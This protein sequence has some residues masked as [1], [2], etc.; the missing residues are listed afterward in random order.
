MGRLDGKVALVSGASRGIG[1]ACAVALAEDGADVLV[2]YL[3]HT[4]DAAETVG[5]IEALGRRAIAYRADVSDRAQ[6]DAM[7]AAALERLGRLDAVVANAYRSVRQPFLEVTPEGLA[8]TLSV[9]LFGAFHVCQA[10]ARAMVERGVEGSVTIVGSIHGE[11]AFAGATSY[12]LAKF[13]LTGMA[14]TA[15]NELARHRVRVNVINPGWIDTPGERNFASEEELRAAA[16]ALPWRRLG[17][18][19][20]IGR[21]AAFLASDDASFISGAVLRADGAQVAAIGG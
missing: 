2:N 4:E 17:R 12:N 18:P 7:V 14:L 11:V 20:E 10:G 16:Q 6:V 3:S 9:T 15:A 13:G 8:A 21:V 19:S 1:R 5:R